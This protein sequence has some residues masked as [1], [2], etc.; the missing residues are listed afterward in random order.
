MLMALGRFG[1]TLNDQRED[2]DMFNRMTRQATLIAVTAI[3]AAPVLC[4]AAGAAGATGQ[5]TAPPPA[6]KPAAEAAE[7]VAYVKLTTTM[8]DIVLE[9]NREKAPISVENFLKYVEAKHYDGTIFHRVIPTFMIQGGGFTSDMEQLQ[10]EAPIKNEWQNGLSNVR[11][12]IAMARRGNQPDSATNQFFINV[13]D[14]AGLDLPR[15]GA[16]Y[17]VFGK[18]IAGMDTVDAIRIV[19]TTDRE[20]KGRVGAPPMQNVPVEP[21]VIESARMISADNAKALEGKPLKRTPDKP[22]RP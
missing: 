15:D 14:N 11:G 4:R 2:Q 12:T 21:V 10:T 9:L 18:V 13:Q 7:A 16:G 19:P 1:M 17:A 3:M 20:A 6:T 8:G 22:A 5:E